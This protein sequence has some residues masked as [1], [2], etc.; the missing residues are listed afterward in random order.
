MF[1]HLPILVM[2]F[3][4][5]DSIYSRA[6]IYHGCVIDICMN[7]YWTVCNNYWTPLL[8]LQT[9]RTTPSK[10]QQWW[11]MRTTLGPGDSK[12]FWL[13]VATSFLLHIPAV[14][15]PMPPKINI[16]SKNSNVLE[17]IILICLIPKLSTRVH[18]CLWISMDVYGCL[19]SMISMFHW[20]WQQSWPPAAA[21]TPL[22]S[23]LMFGFRRS[24]P[25]IRAKNE[26]QN[27]LLG[28]A[29]PF[30]CVMIGV[31]AYTYIYIMYMCLVPIYIY[32][33]MYM[34]LVCTYIYIYITPMTN[35]ICI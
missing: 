13:A 3:F 24:A 11:D 26:G 35:V 4:H 34:C 12:W 10:T 25:G 32:Y 29:S 16:D 27:Q 19:W 17:E 6:T 8:N 22:L 21:A 2:C 15:V 5:P 33:I 30:F 18:G 1:K 31:M 23:H 7:H 20:Q 14:V 28:W 9:M